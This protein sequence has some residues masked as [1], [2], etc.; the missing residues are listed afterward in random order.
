MSNSKTH[1]SPRSFGILFAAV[2]GLAGA[3]PL[4]S[5]HGPRPWALALSLLLLAAALLRPESLAPASR[6][7]LALG[8]RME[9]IVNP[10]VLGV[11]FFGVMAP[12]GLA[13]KLCTRYDP[14]RVRNRK[15]SSWVD[16]PPDAPQHFE[17]PF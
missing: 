1:S 12:I 2:L 6:A 14:L 5:G 10:L 11:I 15:A 3:A 13:M 4:L 7:W 17:K 8:A 9:K 16:C